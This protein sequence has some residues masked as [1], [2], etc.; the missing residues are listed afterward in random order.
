MV[1]GDEGQEPVAR[2]RETGGMI[3]GL[4][5]IWEVLE[6]EEIANRVEFI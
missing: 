1:R 6:L 3:A 4:V 5:L 2:A